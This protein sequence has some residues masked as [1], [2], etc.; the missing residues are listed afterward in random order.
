MSHWGSSRDSSP[1]S[2]AYVRTLDLSTIPWHSESAMEVVLHLLPCLVSPNEP[3]V[4]EIGRCEARADDES[5]RMQCIDITLSHIRAEIGR[6][7]DTNS[8]GHGGPDSAGPAKP[9]WI[10]DSDLGPTCVT[11]LTHLRLLHDTQPNS[12]GTR[13]V[14]VNLTS[15]LQNGQYDRSS[16]L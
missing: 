8:D 6:R 16:P 1:H 15:F 9:D 5:D 2:E 3:A 11:V 7:S 14:P 10:G 12:P 13:C 4:V